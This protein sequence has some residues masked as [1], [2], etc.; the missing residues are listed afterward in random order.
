MGRL[1]PF[2]VT[3]EPAMKLEPVM[4]RVNAGPPAVTPAGAMLKMVGAPGAVTV[5]V[6]ALDGAL[7]GFTTVMDPVAGDSWAGSSAA[8]WV[9]LTK[10]VETAAP[11]H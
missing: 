3:M 10:V 8:S 7:P 11:F 9:A 1:A 5:K 6:K 4:A 2:Q